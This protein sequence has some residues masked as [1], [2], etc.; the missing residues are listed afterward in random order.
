MPHANYL[1]TRI[2]S[3]DGG[4][5]RHL[6][7]AGHG[8]S[9]RNRAA[10]RIDFGAVPRHGNLHIDWIDAE[11]ADCPGVRVVENGVPMW[12]APAEA[13]ILIQTTATQTTPSTLGRPMALQAN[14]FANG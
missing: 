12:L 2:V 11:G 7:A 14:L 3:V 6:Q 13:Q 5:S 8:S 9:R 4:L 10:L 1:R